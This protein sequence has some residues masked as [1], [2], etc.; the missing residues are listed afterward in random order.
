MSSDCI[1][2]LLFTGA[3]SILMLAFLLSWSQPLARWV[4]VVYPSV[5]AVMAYVA[6]RTSPSAEEIARIET[7]TVAATCVA[8][9]ILLLEDAL[10]AYLLGAVLAHEKL[11]F[12]AVAVTLLAA[13]AAW[14]PL[15]QK[16]AR[17][18]KRMAEARP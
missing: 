4:L 10:G 16:L 11:H 18:R 3:T 12:A 17:I 9:P 13:F 8:A 6:S 15:E 7:G 1:W 14:L 2:R 5:G